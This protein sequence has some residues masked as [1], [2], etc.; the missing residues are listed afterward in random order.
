M[1]MARRNIIAG[2][3]LLAVSIG[4]GVLTAGLPDRSLPDTPGPAFLPT[5]IA[6]GLVVLSAA[7]L[8]HGVLEERRGSGGAAGYGVPAR[9]WIALAG[10]VVYVGL[11][12]SLGFVLASLFFFA[13]LMWLYGERNKILIALT[14]VLVPVVLFYL[15][16]AGFQILLP[17]GPL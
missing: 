6:L 4:Y 13:G 8:I 16:T 14:S 12:P 17:R 3:V 10:F 1:T 7:L 11:L 15:F 9:G 2:A 5:L